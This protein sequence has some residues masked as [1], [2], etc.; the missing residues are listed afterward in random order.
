MA[1]YIYI[2]DLSNKGKLG[3]SWR[4]YDFLVNDALGRVKGISKS[5]KMMK[6]NQN[7]RLNRPVQIMIHRGIVNVIVAVDVAKGNN[8]QTIVSNIQEEVNNTLLVATEQVPF[9]VQVKV[10]SII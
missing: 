1:E 7:F 4:V 2:D 10:E 3:I 6:R 8:L 5:S 9:N